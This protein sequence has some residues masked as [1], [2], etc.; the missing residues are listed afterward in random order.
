MGH[1]NNALN[2]LIT[3]NISKVRFTRR[4]MSA[5]GGGGGGGG[6]ISPLP[7]LYQS[8]LLPMFWQL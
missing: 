2:I 7:P 8:L 4:E 6:G 5:G 1:T 3:K